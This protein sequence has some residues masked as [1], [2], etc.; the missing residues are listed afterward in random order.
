MSSWLT[1]YIRMYLAFLV[2]GLGEG[3]REGKPVFMGLAG[4]AWGFIGLEG[5]IGLD[6]MR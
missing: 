5:A 4:W 2:W 6:E 1:G 3:K